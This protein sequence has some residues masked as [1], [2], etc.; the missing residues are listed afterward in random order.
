MSR[1]HA[2]AGLRVMDAVKEY[3]LPISRSFFLAGQ[4]PYPYMTSVNACLYL[5]TNGD[6]VK[7]AVNIGYP[8]RARFAMRS[9]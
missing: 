8:C 3:G 4:L 9:N 1:N 2:D 7:Q 6:E 5:S